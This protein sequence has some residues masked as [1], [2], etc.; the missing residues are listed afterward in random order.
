MLMINRAIRGM[1]TTRM[2]MVI[3]MIVVVGRI[4]MKMRTK[5]KKQMRM[6]AII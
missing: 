1:R 3:M 4:F 2:K 6:T 5:M